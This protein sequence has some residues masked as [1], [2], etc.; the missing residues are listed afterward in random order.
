LEVGHVVGGPT[1][2]HKIERVRNAMGEFSISEIVE[3]GG[4]VTDC[5]GELKCTHATHHVYTLLGAGGRGQIV[6]K[7]L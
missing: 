7:F 1:F 5:M 3:R 4:M 6:V 2:K